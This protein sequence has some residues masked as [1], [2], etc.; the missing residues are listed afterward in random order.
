MYS[1]IGGVELACTISGH[2]RTRVFEFPGARATEKIDEPHQTIFESASMRAVVTS[3]LVDF[4]ARSSFGDH[5]DISPSLRHAVEEISPSVAKA[6]GTT[7]FVV[8]E[9]SDDLTAV[10]M[11]RGECSVSDEVITT[12]GDHVSMLIGGRE[13]KQFITAWATV[14]GSWPELPADQT[15][16]NMVMACVRAGQQHAGAIRKL[17]DQRCLVTDDGRF[18]VIMQP[19]MHAAVTGVAPL[20]AANY[21]E[22]TA[23]LRD[24]IDRMKRDIGDARVALLARSMYCEETGDD[25]FQQL[26]YLHLWQSVVDTAGFMYDPRQVAAADAPLV[27]SKTPHELRDYRHDIAHGRTDDMDMN[28]LV[29]LQLNVNQ[30]VR[31]KYF[32]GSAADSD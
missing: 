23:S 7:L 25:S 15:L 14:D 11:S 28:F 30:L 1:G 9:E 12:D 8:I 5:Y 3:D 17:L 10:E 26:L 32:G 21:A 22:R 20:D 27:G 18:V 29:D 2:R 4:F 19:T 6:N 31:G 24:A 13:G 16:V